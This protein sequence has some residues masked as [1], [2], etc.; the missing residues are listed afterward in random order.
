MYFTD[1]EIARTFEV[2][3]LHAGPIVKLL[4]GWKNI[5]QETLH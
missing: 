4:L 1:V 5:H 3:M 2:S